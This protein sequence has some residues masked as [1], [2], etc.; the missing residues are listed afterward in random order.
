MSLRSGAVVKKKKLIKPIFKKNM[1]KSEKEWK[2]QKSKDCF[3]W[4][5][6]FSNINIFYNKQFLK[7]KFKLI[8][9]IFCIYQKKTFQKI[10]KNT[11]TTKTILKRVYKWKKKQNKGTSKNL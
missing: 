10:K 6:R 2:N 7:I 4:F 8:S 1:Q 9:Y 3:L 5:T 11:N